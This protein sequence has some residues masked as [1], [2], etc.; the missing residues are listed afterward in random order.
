MGLTNIGKDPYEIALDLTNKP[1]SLTEQWK[2]VLAEMERED[3]DK[4][5]FA[6]DPGYKRKREEV[7][8]L[9][10]KIERALTSEEV[11]KAFGNYDDFWLDQLV[12]KETASIILGVAIGRQLF[13]S[14]CR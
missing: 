7:E 6:I 13:G 14:Q 9:S 5:Y 12:L 10:E 11:K 4:L 3:W 1:L 2:K 8:S